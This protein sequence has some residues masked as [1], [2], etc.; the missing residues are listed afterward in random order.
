MSQDFHLNCL[1]AE[2]PEPGVGTL[3]FLLRRPLALRG[4]D[5]DQIT[6]MTEGQLLYAEHVDCVQ[7]ALVRHLH[8]TCDQSGFRFGVATL[9]GLTDLAGELDLSGDVERAVN[10]YSHAIALVRITYGQSEAADV[11][12]QGFFRNVSL[13]GLPY[14]LASQED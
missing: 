11:S 1:R 6:V 8:G 12:D 5:P 9:L 10:I 4:P 14:A 7:T 3:S 13:G 2:P